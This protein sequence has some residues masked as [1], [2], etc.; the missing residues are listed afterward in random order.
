MAFYSD[1]RNLRKSKGFTIR[2]VANRSGVSTAYIS[3]LENGNRGIPSPEILMRLSDGLNISYTDLMAMAGYLKDPSEPYDV[4][5][6]PLNLR[7]LL[8][9]NDLSFDGRLLTPEDK[10]WVER[11]LTVLFWKDSRHKD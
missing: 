8:R 10:E 1:L 11:M 4:Q 9:E 3:Q 5:R 2:E 7:R 6:H